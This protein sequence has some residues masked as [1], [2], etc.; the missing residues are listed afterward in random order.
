M[1]EQKTGSGLTFKY[2][3]YTRLYMR[4]MDQWRTRISNTV[5]QRE[6][7]TRGKS[8]AEGSAYSNLDNADQF[9]VVVSK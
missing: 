6:V 5:R 1:Q 7:V 3:L 2:V 9:Y 8:K 4:V